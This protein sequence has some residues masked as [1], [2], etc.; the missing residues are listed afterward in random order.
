[1]RQ[2]H[3]VPAP[4][5]AGNATGNGTTAAAASAGP[6]EAEKEQASTQVGSDEEVKDASLHSNAHGAVAV[7]PKKRQPTLQEGTSKRPI[8][9]SSGH[10]NAKRPTRGRADD[11]QNDDDDDDDDGGEGGR[12]L[13]SRREEGGGQCILS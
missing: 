5:P 2:L 1:M 12:G 6:T 10:A 7:K 3:I 13:G 11:D 8:S 4:S 9:R